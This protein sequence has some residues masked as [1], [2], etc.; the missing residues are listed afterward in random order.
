MIDPGIITCNYLFQTKWVTFIIFFYNLRRK[1]NLINVFTVATFF[2]IKTETGLPTQGSFSIDS[3]PSL[4]RRTHLQTLA[5]FKA[6]FPYFLQISM[7]FCWWKPELCLNLTLYPLFRDFS[8]HIESYILLWCIKPC[9][10]NTQPLVRCI[11]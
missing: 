10:E 2:S 7:N 5:Y 8:I 6:P 4:K 3:Q 9:V 11:P 1:S